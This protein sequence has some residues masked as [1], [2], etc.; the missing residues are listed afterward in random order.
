MRQRSNSC[1][2]AQGNRPQEQMAA[3]LKVVHVVLSLDCG[4]LERIVLDLVREGRNFGQRVAVVCL[5]RPGT[6][7][8]HVEAAGAQVFCVHKQPG[9]RMKVIGQLKSVLSE[10]RPDIVHTHQ[11]PV[12]FYAGRAARR[13]GVPVVVHTQHGKLPSLRLRTRLMSRLAA[14][15]CARFFCVS[16]EI[17]GQVTAAHLVSSGKLLVLPNGIEAQRFRQPGDSHLLRQALGIAGGAPVL[18]TVGRLTEVKHQDLLIRAFGRVREELP[19]A[20]LL[21]VGDGPLMDELRAL[22]TSLGLSKH[23]HFVGYQAQPERYLQLMDVFVLSSRFEGMPLAV[24][25]AWA[26]GVPVVASH[27]GGLPELIDDG[28][29]GLLFPPGDE[30]ALKES[31][32]KILVD[33]NFARQLREAGSQHV[34]SEF[35]LSRMARNYHGHYLEVLHQ[36]GRRSL[37]PCLARN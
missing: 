10:L 2:A 29:N 36:L 15:Y 27:V 26:A 37:S 1:I 25:E 17:A 35:S 28:Q 19:D 20:H 13:V 30:G 16:K 34:T 9:I 23:T 4:G 12:L 3:S 33:L 7:A 21:L 6:L 14:R 24:L 8:P 32:C 18:G 31:I 22:A 5:E 11:I